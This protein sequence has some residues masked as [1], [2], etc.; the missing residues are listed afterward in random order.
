MSNKLV[1]E[2]I[3]GKVA[4]IT[5]AASGIGRATAH[6]FA[7]AGASVA[8]LDV[9]EDRGEAVAVEIVDGGGSARF[10]RCDVTQSNSCKETVESVL[11]TFGG[12]HFLVNAAGVIQRGSVLETSEAEW[13]RTMAVNLKG[14]FLI[15]KFALLHM[16]DSG[17]GAIVNIASGWG[18]AGGRRA[19]SYCTSKGGVVLLTK[20]MAL[21]HA[22]DNVRVNCVCP[23]DTD[24]PM[25]HSEAS[26]LG[27]PY[28]EF[29]ADA[30]DRPMGRIGTPEEVAWS[31]L[32]LASDA[33]SYIT[34][35]TLVVDGGGLLGAGD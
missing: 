30:A 14:I 31:V 15:S 13:D 25:L 22:S 7:Q 18:L 21:D 32:F 2:G 17:G 24:T 35:A 34:G 29:M 9:Q 20:A 27:I 3:G 12:L 33:A 8:A 23:G 5:G 19:A 26:Q 1:L 4:V 6:L 11:E 10:Y 28:K 16:I